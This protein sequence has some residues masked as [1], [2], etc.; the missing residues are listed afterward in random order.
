[1]RHEDVAKRVSKSR[2]AIT[3]AVRL[4]NLPGEIQGLLAD[5][6]I[7]AGAARALV[8]LEDA[9][10]A[11]AIAEQA[12]SEQWSVRQVEEAVRE[13][14]EEPD[15][16]KKSGKRRTEKKRLAQIIALEELLADRLGTN[17]KINY[18]SRG[19][20]KMVIK[21]GSLDD[22]ERIYRGLTGE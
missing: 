17:V 20:G 16:S 5:G 19:G 18:G 2:S 12:A 22:L 6:R 4:L 9:A 14:R 7:S 10:F 13:R 11:V 15:P 3:N 1:M 8:G 21:F